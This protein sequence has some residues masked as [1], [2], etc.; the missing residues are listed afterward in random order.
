MMYYLPTLLPG[1]HI[2]VCTVLL[3]FVGYFIIYLC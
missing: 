3:A 2:C 1:V